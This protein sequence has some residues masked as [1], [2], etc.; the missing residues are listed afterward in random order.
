[1]VSPS[2]SLR[3]ARLPTANPRLEQGAL[4][5]IQPGLRAARSKLLTEQAAGRVAFL[6]LDAEAWEIPRAQE[7]GL[8]LAA[9]A[10]TLLV[11][12]IGGS[13]L[14]ARALEV[15]L[16]DPSSGRRL[17]VADT[18]DP[19]RTARWLRTLD[20][21][22][23][24]VA[25]ISKSG[26]TVETA[27][28]F[29]IVIPWLRAADPVGFRDRLVIV[30][31]RRRGTLRPFAEALDLPTLPVPDDVG[32]RFSILTAVGMLPAAFL[33]LDV[34]GIFRGARGMRTRVGMDSPD[35]NPAF[36]F[37]AAHEALWGPARTTVLMPYNDR[38]RA[39]GEWFQQLWGESLGKPTA[40]GPFGWTPVLAMGPVD[41]HSQLQLYQDGPADKVFTFLGVRAPDED[42]PIPALDGPENGV[43]PWLAGKSL[44][45]LLEAERQGTMAA[46]VAA[47]RPVLDLQIDL[48]DAQN[49]GALIVLF[50]AATAFAGYL[51]GI[52]PFDQPG[53]EQGKRFASGLLGR[54]EYRADA[55]RVDRLLRD[56]G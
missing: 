49:F 27:A 39:F 37:A 52:D 18:V 23:T 20:P 25:V 21:R 48:L 15:A 36:A 13:A 56:G 32:G 6:G 26:E 38:L 47:G 46:L 12:G 7:I 11:L 35:D 8:A 54:P 33:G 40:S 43:A 34:D 42:L 19:V 24:A 9:R 5:A 51:R 55:E 41:Q 4:D 16:A 1:M 53:V 14:G 28:L 10:D 30:T 2:L 31:D 45:Q 29:R 44:H 50:E 3:L 17:E 22:R